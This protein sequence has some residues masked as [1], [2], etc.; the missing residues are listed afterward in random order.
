MNI[1]NIKTRKQII[2]ERKANGENLMAIIVD[3]MFGDLKDMPKYNDHNEIARKAYEDIKNMDFSD[4][5]SY[6]NSLYLLVEHFKGLAEHYLDC[7]DKE[8]YILDDNGYL[9]E[10]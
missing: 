3:G 4:T 1:P 5:K 7:I 10:I 9:E 2:E 8:K 6:I